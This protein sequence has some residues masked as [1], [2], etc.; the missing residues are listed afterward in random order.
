[1]SNKSY[2]ISYP[3]QYPYGATWHTKSNC[4]GYWGWY[5]NYPTTT[6]YRHKEYRVST[7]GNSPIVNGVVHLRENDY[8]LDFYLELNGT[9]LYKRCSSQTGWYNYQAGSTLTS[10]SNTGGVTD[11]KSMF[12]ITEPVPPS[13]TVMVNRL[14]EK[15]KDSDFNLAVSVVE[16]RET[17]ESIASAALGI[18][19]AARS[20]RK[21]NLDE[22]IRQL[23]RAGGGRIPKDS[24]RDARRAL[25][26]RDLA[27]TWLSL[28]MGWIPLLGDIYSA[29]KLRYLYQPTKSVVASHISKG[30]V[31]PATGSYVAV[32]DASLVSKYRWEAFLE[33]DSLT[34][35]F[36]ERLG[37]TDPAT[38]LWELTPFS[39][40]LDYLL[41]VGDL[42]N[43]I[44]AVNALPVTSVTKTQY[45]KLYIKAGPRTGNA[46]NL[47]T[48][49]REFVD[50]SGH[51]V[52]KEIQLSRKVKQNLPSGF[53]L[54]LQV[55]RSVSVSPETSLKRTADVLALAY[56]NLKKL[57]PSLR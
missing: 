22:S 57:L 11:Y 52:R 38:I 9:A 10:M 27:N 44:H 48:A 34:P 1:M 7:G 12:S 51:F 18:A 56:S 42:L 6:L 32:Q 20:L 31:L 53:D 8:S 54:A 28:R 4:N 15:W 39:F 2:Y 41:P 49:Y 14:F 30:S 35:S 50:I 47:N 21:G 3:L 5:I 43:A 46:V 45:R 36:G 16:G 33:T 13:D 17:L 40:L 29:N 26:G 37:L 19:R 55:P 24:L 25:S 23:S